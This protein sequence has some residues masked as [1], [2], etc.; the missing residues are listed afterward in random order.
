MNPEGTGVNLP[1][2]QLG[3]GEN[4]AQ[5]NIKEAF[6]PQK[7]VTALDVMGQNPSIT[8]I[9]EATKLADAANTEGF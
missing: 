1:K 2:P 6:F 3:F 5:G 7:P 9:T 4:L 8:D